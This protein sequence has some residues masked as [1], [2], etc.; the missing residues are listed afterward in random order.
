MHENADSSF[1]QS[2]PE[3]QVRLEFFIFSCTIS[4]ET[5]DFNAERVTA[6]TFFIIFFFNK[7]TRKPY[8]KYGSL[9]ISLEHICV[10]RN[11]NAP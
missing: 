10:R 4:M 8:N 3:W 9:L 5:L 11:E 7:T 2:C 6:T 1:P